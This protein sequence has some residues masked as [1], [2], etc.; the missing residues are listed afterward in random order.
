MK[1]KLIE[2]LLYGDIVGWIFYTYNFE[3]FPQPFE[4]VHKEVSLRYDNSK[5]QK[6]YQKWLIS[7]KSIRSEIDNDKVKPYSIEEQIKKF[8]PSL[9]EEGLK[10]V[11]ESIKNGFLHG[12]FNLIQLKTINDYIDI[13]ADL[14]VIGYTKNFKTPTVRDTNLYTFIKEDDRMFPLLYSIRSKG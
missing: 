9:S 12:G 8:V 1:N 10:F 2:R 4:S 14:N 11:A 7:M 3:P 5:L 13:N 6:V